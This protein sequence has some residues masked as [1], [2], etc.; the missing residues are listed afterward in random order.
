MYLQSANGYHWTAQ[1]PLKGSGLHYIV[2]AAAQAVFTLF[3][4]D[5]VPTHEAVLQRHDCKF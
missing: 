4:T 5:Y 1:A 3:I 2:L